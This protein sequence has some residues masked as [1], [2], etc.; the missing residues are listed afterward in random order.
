MTGRQSLP[1]LYN[2]Y[3]LTLIRRTFPISCVTFITFN[4]G[5][6]ISHTGQ[7]YEHLKQNDQDIISDNYED[8]E[9]PR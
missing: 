2:E 1:I 8:P 4:T 3:I 9:C 5:Q 6:R 7:Q